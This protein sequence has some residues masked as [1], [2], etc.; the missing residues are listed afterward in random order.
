MNQFGGIELVA[1]ARRAL[2]RVHQECLPHEH[3]IPGS[4]L[5]HQHR[6]LP[7]VGVHGGAGR[8]VHEVPACAVEIL[9]IHAG[10]LGGGGD[11][12]QRAE[13]PSRTRRLPCIDTLLGFS[14]N[15]KGGTDGGD[16]MRSTSQAGGKP[17]SG[18]AIPRVCAA[19]LDSAGGSGGV[20]EASHPSR[21]SGAERGNREPRRA[22]LLRPPSGNRRR[23]GRRGLLR[24]CLPVTGRVARRFGAPD[25]ALRARHHGRDGQHRQEKCD[26]PHEKLLSVYPARG[27]LQSGSECR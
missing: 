2:L 1:A 10:H 13:Q 11:S 8:H 3:E 6:H 4:G 12:Q 17:G 19:V 22:R 26:H 16:Q 27:S 24:R 9:V 7:G 25:H 23:L 5:G 21:Q 18:G 20:A 15:E 14:K